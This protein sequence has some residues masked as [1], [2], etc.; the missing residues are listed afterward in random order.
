MIAI[1][2]YKMGNIRS[3]FN[4]LQRLGVD[5]CVTSNHIEIRE[6]DKIILPGVGS[7]DQGM[8]NLNEE[9]LVKVLEEVVFQKKTPILGICLGLQLFCRR[10]EEG[11]SRGLGWIDADVVKF[12]F[13]E[14]DVLRVPHVGWNSIKKNKESFLLKEIAQENRFYFTHSYHVCCDRL[15]DPVAYTQYGYD[16]VSVVEKENLMGVQ[17]HPETSHKDGMQLLRNFIELKEEVKIN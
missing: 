2:D 11:S 10:S 5:V 14:E 15:E 17:F 7:F 1:V 4:R 13:K 12:N 6:A 9:G 3:I 8:Y 16:I